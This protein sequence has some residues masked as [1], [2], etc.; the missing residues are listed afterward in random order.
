MSSGKAV[1]ADAI[2]VEVYMVRGFTLLRKR[3]NLFYCMLRKEAI[4]Q[5]LKDV[6]INHQYKWKGILKSVV[7]LDS[8][9]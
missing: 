3:T 2:S 9:C 5:Q 8:Q 7:I 1:C 4:S 6:T